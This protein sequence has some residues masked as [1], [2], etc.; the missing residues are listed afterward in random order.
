MKI[1]EILTELSFQGRK[2]T[3]DCSGHLAGYQWAQ[4]HPG[5]AAASH[6]ASF[7]TGAGIAADQ[8]KT[9]NVVRPKI[10]DMK[11][12]FGPRP[13]MKAKPA[14]PAAPVNSTIPPKTA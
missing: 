5:Q 14:A 9:G 10:R 4:T 12:R 7:N 8:Q 3:K 2:C 6:S 1:S 13:V 11:G